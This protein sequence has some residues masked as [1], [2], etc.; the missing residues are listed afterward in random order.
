MILQIRHFLLA[1]EGQDFVEYGLLLAG[2]AAIAWPGVEALGP[3]VKTGFD[4]A[5]ALFS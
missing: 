1:E 3:I 5:T 2:I 4:K